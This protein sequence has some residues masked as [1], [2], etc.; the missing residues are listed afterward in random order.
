MARFSE[1]FKYSIGKG[2]LN[3]RNGCNN[4]EE[5]AA[6]IQISR[7]ILFLSIWGIISA[8]SKV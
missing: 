8:I 1:E 7:F 6:E 5:I 3:Q 4:H 2:M